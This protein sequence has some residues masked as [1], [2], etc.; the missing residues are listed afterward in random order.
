M[1]APLRD[2]VHLEG[3]I[4]PATWVIHVAAVSACATPRCVV[5]MILR[6]GQ[7]DPTPGDV[8]PV[9]LGGRVILAGWP[10]AVAA[11]APRISNGDLDFDTFVQFGWAFGRAPEPMNAVAEWVHAIG[12]PNRG[13]DLAR[14][15]DAR[16]AIVRVLLASAR[17]HGTGAGSQVAD[18][19][20][21]WLRGDGGTVS[22]ADWIAM[23]RPFRGDEIGA[24][25]LDSACRV[26]AAHR[27]FDLALAVADARVPK[28]EKAEWECRLQDL[29]EALS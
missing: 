2:P 22:P 3:M 8:V 12:D 9:F 16:N 19:L 21:A 17:R 6:E 14:V 7:R 25:A 18:A 1:I 23:G 27:P 4:D 11:S 20:E 10:S 15:A 26:I 29:D 24:Q 28:D 5:R 13:L